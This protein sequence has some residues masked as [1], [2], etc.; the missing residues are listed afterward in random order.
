MFDCFHPLKL[1]QSRL[2]KHL[3]RFPGRI[4]E[5]V[6]VESG[7]ITHAFEDPTAWG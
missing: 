3:Q 7:Q 6:K 1:R 5:Q 4:G 2:G